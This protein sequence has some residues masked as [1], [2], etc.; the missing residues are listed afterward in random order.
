MLSDFVIFMIKIRVNF[1]DIYEEV[2]MLLFKHSSKY[3]MALAI[4]FLITLIPA[5]Q[6]QASAH[7]TLEKT[8]L[9]K[10]GL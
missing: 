2:S 8:L 1:N 3:I 9:K 5:F 6:H 4:A 7:A 10:K